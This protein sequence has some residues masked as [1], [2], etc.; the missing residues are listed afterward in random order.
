MKRLNILITHVSYQAS[1]GSIIKLLR[2]SKKYLF[3]IIGCDSIEKG[4]SSGSMLV[5]KFYHINTNTEFDYISKINEISRLEKIDL[6]VSAEEEDLILFK[7]YEIHQAL[8]E[9]IPDK[10]IFELFKDKHLATQE[11]M[12]KGIP[13]PKTIMNYNDFLVSDSSKYIKRKR[14]SC[15]SRGIS[16]FGRNEISEKQKFFSDDYITQ[17][18][19]QGN[20]YTIDMFCD[21]N[22]NPLSII[23]RKTLSSKDGTTFKCII[24]KQEELIDICQYVYDIYHIPGF[25]NIQFIVTDK[26]YFIELNPRT[27]AT[28]IAS[29]LASTNYMDLYVSHFL[30]NE[31]LPSYSDIMQ[32]VRWRSIISRYYQETIL[33]PGDI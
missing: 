13:V 25:S 10:K 8:Y 22:G 9:H 4:F 29:A 16:V 26:P 15:C 27:A 6:I 14:V 5:D 7:K 31:E 2:D 11:L 24:E 20:M 33:F 1:A 3:R 12:R 21:K 30:F 17:E 19:L 23:P 18:F 28:M 32:S